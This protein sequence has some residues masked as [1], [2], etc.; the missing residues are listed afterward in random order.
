MVLADYLTISQIIFYATF[1]IAFLAFG[2]IIISIL[3]YLLRIARHVENISN[4]IEIAT[5]EARENLSKIIEKLLSL[6]F[7]SRFIKKNHR[8]GR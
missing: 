8:K 4:N 6:P 3:Y 1:S 7:I 2:I 5:D